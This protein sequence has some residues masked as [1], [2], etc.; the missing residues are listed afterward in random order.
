VPSDINRQG[1][2]IAS[3]T[4][5][6]LPENSEEPCT[7]RRSSKDD[8]SERS[9]TSRSTSDQEQSVRWDGRPRLAADSAE[10]PSP[11]TIIEHLREIVATMPPG[12]SV[13]LPIDW[14][15][16]ELEGVGEAAARQTAEQVETDYGVDQVAEICK[17]RPGT[18]REWIRS[19]RLKAYQFNGREYRVTRMALAEFLENQ[20]SSQTPAHQPGAS[21]INTDLGSWRRIRGAVKARS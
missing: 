21:A 1:I 14:L 17:R 8:L 4:V 16:V 7:S 10:T 9:S 15:R 19:G 5:S 6:G 2:S 18:V 11:M 3:Q 13:S 20:R 12:S